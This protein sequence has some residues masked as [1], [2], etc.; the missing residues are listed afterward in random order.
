M[1]D[2]DTRKLE[3]L[4]KKGFLFGYNKK[5]LL[6][7]F[8]EDHLKHG[9]KSIHEKVQNILSQLD[10]SHDI[11]SIRLVTMPRLFFKTF[12]P[13]NFYLCYDS[14]PKMICMIAE[15]TNTY[16]EMSYYLMDN[17]VSSKKGL[18]FRVH[19]HFHVSPFFN[20][21]GEYQFDVWDDPESLGIGISYFVNNRKVFYANFYG[22]KKP[23]TNY[24]ALKLLWKYPFTLACVF[25]RILYQAGKLYFIQKLPA[26]TKPKADDTYLLRSQPLTIFQKK[27]LAKLEK[28]CKFIFKEKLVMVL[29][30]S[31]RRYFGSGN[32]ESLVEMYIIKNDFFK[33]VFLCGEVGL[34][35]SYMRGEWDSKNLEKVLAFMIAYKSDIE[36]KFYG[37]VFI[38]FFN[39]LA[40][41]L[42]KNKL[43][44]SHDNI[45]KHYDLGNK[46]YQCFL[47]S[48]MCY[49]S[50]LFLKE[51]DSLEMAQKQKVERLI[52]SLN[53][54]ADSEVL[55]IGS[56]WG[57]AATRI[58]EKYG[59]KVRTITLSVEQKSYVEALIEKKNIKDLITVELIDYRCLS[60]K[61]DAI[62]SI[63][64]IEA[65]GHDY[66]SLFFNVCHNCLKPGGRLA[67]QCITYPDQNYDAYCKDTDFI[68]KHIFPGGHLPSLGVIDKIIKQQTTFKQLGALNIA[69]SYAKTLA[70]WKKSF[71]NQKDF[72][73]HLGFD[74]LFYRKWI[75][76]FSL[77]KAA[78][79]TNFLGCYQLLYEKM[80]T[81][82]G[83][84]D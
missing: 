33:S 71:S 42:K 81:G 26:K 25:P 78:F 48:S 15:V 53:L 59:A 79:Q 75:Y 10:R 65:V 22:E 1:I 40:H 82:E 67:L 9:H 58:A 72:I 70:F 74:E 3:T 43:G 54:N 84:S 69:G 56:G 50:G 44:Q 61:F 30:D 24:Y 13:V 34:G 7:L 83:S 55:E 49:S 31:T 21:E 38:Q 60:G 52:D 19:K 18:R 16:H 73:F 62:L 80:T 51:S 29:P 11:D 17:P 41:R 47:D 32:D 46:F 45:S 39:K 8:D 57:Y 76:Y 20:E 66:L 77:C 23:L 37:N 5:R 36:P 64:M 68:K 2:V 63:E 4:N 35:E 6:S 28:S 14:D 27:V 12:R